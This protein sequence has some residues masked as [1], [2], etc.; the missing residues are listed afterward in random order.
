VKRDRTRYVVV[1]CLVAF[2]VMTF[3]MIRIVFLPHLVA[4]TAFLPLERWGALTGT[5]PLR[6]RGGIAPA[7]P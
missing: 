2:H 7:D 6:A 4:L 1:A 3:L 5:R